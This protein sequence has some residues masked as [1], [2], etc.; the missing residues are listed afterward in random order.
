MRL[1]KS[2]ATHWIECINSLEPI[3]CKPAMLLGFL[4]VYT[5]KLSVFPD[6][7][8]L[9][10]NFSETLSSLEIEGTFSQVANRVVKI[11]L[12][13]P[14]M[15]S[16]DTLSFGIN[17]DDNVQKRLEI[18]FDEADLLGKTVPFYFDISNYGDRSSLV[19]FFAQYQLPQLCLAIGDQPNLSP[20]NNKIFRDTFFGGL[21]DRGWINS[22]GALVFPLDEGALKTFFIETLQSFFSISLPQHITEC[23]QPQLDAGKRQYDQKLKLLSGFV[24]HDAIAIFIKGLHRD[25]RGLADE[26]FHQCYI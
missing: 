18:R 17:H 7:D 12:N 24:Q 10:K 20:Q 16:V 19:A 13:N 9:E 15:K 23:L 5:N 4:N 22:T 8:F 26:N 6:I 3:Y 25:G 11:S 14:I 21:E 1:T 2:D